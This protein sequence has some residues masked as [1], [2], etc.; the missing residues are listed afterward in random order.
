MEQFIT[1]FTSIST[2]IT[3]LQLANNR[4][5]PKGINMLMNTKWTN[6]KLLNLENNNIKLEGA[7]DLASPQ[8]GWNSLQYLNLSIC[9][10]MKIIR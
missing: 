7:K 1:N 6:L 8:H 2:K 3:E 4:I 5:G 10:V 9:W